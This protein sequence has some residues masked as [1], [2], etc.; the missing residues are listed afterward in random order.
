[1]IRGKAVLK[2]A[3]RSYEISEKDLAFI[4]P[5]AMHQFTNPYGE[6]FEFICIVPNRGA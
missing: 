6:D 1:V 3:E 4:P 5:N 2:V